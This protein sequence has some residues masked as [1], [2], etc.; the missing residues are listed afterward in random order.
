MRWATVGSG[1]RKARAISS[2]VRPESRRSVSATRASVESTG[3]QEMKTRRR[4]SSPT[5]SSIAATRSDSAGSSLAASSWPSSS[6]LRSSSLPRRRRSIARCFAVAMSQAPGL[7]G[8]PDSGHCSSAATRESC[9]SSSARPTSRT[10][11]ARAGMTLAASIRQT[12]SIARCVVFAP[13]AG[14]PSRAPLR[15]RAPLVLVHA[16][17]DLLG[18]RGFLALDLGTEI[19]HLVH[20]ADLERVAV[21]GGAAGGPFDR[22]FLRLQLPQPVAAAEG[23]AGG[24]PLH[25]LSLR[26]LLPQPV[27]ADQL[28]RLGEGSV[29]HRALPAREAD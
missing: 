14:L 28:F 24:G 5:G 27:A 21:Q 12:A 17:V 22:L 7:S 11:R 23:G 8:T 29:G 9:A 1:T 3:W 15:S 20:L 10:I 6:C 13:T 18:Q 2:V 16:L 26:L 4:R 25:L 19:R